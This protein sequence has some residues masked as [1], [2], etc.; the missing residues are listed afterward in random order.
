V[1][2]IDKIMH[3]IIESWPSAVF[4]GSSVADLF[5]HLVLSQ[6]ASGIVI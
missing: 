1:C 4:I 6:Y 5:I 3:A 2:V